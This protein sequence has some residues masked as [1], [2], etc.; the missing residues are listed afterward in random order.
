MLSEPGVRLGRVNSGIQ[1]SPG[2]RIPVETELAAMTLA[3]RLCSQSI[4]QGRTPGTARSNN[5]EFVSPF[6]KKPRE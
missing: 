2:R 4:K 5:I 6:W 1:S 3:M